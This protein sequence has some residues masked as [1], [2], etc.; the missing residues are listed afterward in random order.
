MNF[1]FLLAIACFVGATQ[2]LPN[3]FGSVQ[4]AAVKGQL[5]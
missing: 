1:R 3:L 2:A 4:S 5:M